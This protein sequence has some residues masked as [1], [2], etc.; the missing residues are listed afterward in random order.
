M[1]KNFEEYEIQFAGL[2]N[3]EHE[4]H[5]QIDET[6]FALFEYEEFNSVDVEVNLL[7]D[8]T[9]NM[10]EL[11]FH[12]DGA[13][14]VV[15]DLSNVPYEQP[16]SSELFLK[17]KFGNEYNDEDDE[18]LILPHGT[19]TIE[20]QQYIYE[21]IILAVPYKKVHPK[22]K[23]GTMKSDILDKLEELSPGNK[24]E[25]KQDPRWDELKKLLN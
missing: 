8:K 18:Y 9:S 24:K 11:T 22:V 14:G 23:D 12:I 16:V 2:K 19:H 5:Y 4:F 17:V 7:L 15:C 6:F 25:E 1:M 3:G 10:L 13:V 20:V 21:A